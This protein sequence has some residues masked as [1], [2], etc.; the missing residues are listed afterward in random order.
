MRKTIKITVPE[1]T[2][3]ADTIVYKSNEDYR[4]EI[5]G[6]GNNI[7]QKLLDVLYPAIMKK[8]KKEFKIKD[9]MLSEGNN[10]VGIM[11]CYFPT[12]LYYTS[13]DKK[14]K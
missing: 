1:F 6:F 5:K 8:I 2:F 4:V 11:S 3:E 10:R 9:I 14:D 12:G 13:V 7:E